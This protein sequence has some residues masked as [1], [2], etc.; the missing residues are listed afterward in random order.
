MRAHLALTWATL[1][2]GSLWGAPRPRVRAE[3]GRAW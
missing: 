3:P 2:I 1:A